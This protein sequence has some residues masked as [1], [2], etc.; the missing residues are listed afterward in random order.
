MLSSAAIYN[1]VA[2]TVGPLIAMTMPCQDIERDQI[3]VG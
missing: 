1:D 3:W 2:Y